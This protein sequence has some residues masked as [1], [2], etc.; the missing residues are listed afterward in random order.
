MTNKKWNRIGDVPII[1]AGTYANNKTVA[2]HQP[3][4]ANILSEM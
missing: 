3:V 1:G 2:Y 4:G